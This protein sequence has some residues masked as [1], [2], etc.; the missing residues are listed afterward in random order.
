MKAGGS[1]VWYFADGYLPEKSGS[2][3]MEAHEA[4]MLLNVDTQEAHITL[5]FYFDDRDPAKGISTTVEG[6][7]IIALRLDHAEDIGGLVIE[8]Q[9]Q[10]AIRVSSDRRIIAQ[11]GRLDTTQ[12]SMAYYSPM[13]YYED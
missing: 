13:G 11:F 1:N 2:G 7:R 12:S 3:S 8:P 6:E 9:T 10:Y 4:L 5:D